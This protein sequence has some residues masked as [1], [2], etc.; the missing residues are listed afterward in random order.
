MD[1]VQDIATLCG[2]N[3]AFDLRR[4][5]HIVAHPGVPLT[6]FVDELRA[7]LRCSSLGDDDTAGGLHWASFSSRFRSL[8]TMN[9]RVSDC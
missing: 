4:G 6:E 3:I 1:F 8:A 5:G 7:D 9:P 2:G